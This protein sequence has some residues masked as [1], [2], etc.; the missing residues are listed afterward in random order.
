MMNIE[1]SYNVN[2]YM[3]GDIEVAK[4]CIRKICFKNGMCVTVSPTVYIYTGGEENGFVIGFLNYPRFPKTREEIWD[5]AKRTAVVLRE[6]LCQWSYLLVA[7]DKTS[8]VS[9]KPENS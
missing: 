7:P 5:T 1:G 2:L 6:E 9:Y 3:A 8:W 4:Q